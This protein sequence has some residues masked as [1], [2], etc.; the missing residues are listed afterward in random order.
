MVAYY[1]VLSCEKRTTNLIRLAVEERPRFHEHRWMVT[2][3]VRSK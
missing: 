1:V 3:N 2:P